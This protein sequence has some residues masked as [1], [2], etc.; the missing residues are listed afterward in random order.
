M[1]GIN[2]V[3]L[4]GN[5]G[6]DPELRY[7]QGNNA[8]A[9]LNV[10]TTRS[11]FNKTTNER[12]EETEWHRVTLWGKDAEN[13]NKYLT[14][15]RQVYIEGRL[16][17][18]KYEDKDGV[19]KYST[20]IVAETIQYLGGR[21]AGGEEGGGG[22]GGEYSG[23][24][25]GGRGGGGGGGGYGG[26]GGGGGR[27]RGGG[28]GDYGGG[29]GGGGG[30]RGGGGG[31]GGGRGNDRGAPDQGPPEGGG[32]DNYIPDPADDDIPF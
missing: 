21:G 18:R 5:L 32:F 10:A 23:G 27:S 20:D 17:T 8:V 24:G 19:T 1:A 31:G 22:G 16:Q 28:G 26:G 15:G 13:A 30:G 2:K 29:G 6:R 7:T 14:K 12:V 11:Y 9:T 3:I 25:G 4:I